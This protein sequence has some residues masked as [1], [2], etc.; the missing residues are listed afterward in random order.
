MGKFPCLGLGRA[1]RHLG[2]LRWQRFLG[3][4]FKHAVR[5]NTTHVTYVCLP[6]FYYTFA[7][8]SILG[9]DPFT[10]FPFP[11]SGA[12]NEQAGKTHAAAAGFERDRRRHVMRS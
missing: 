3:F 1:L 10:F 4:P 12:A 6:S 11:L 5:P 9:L 7:D 8:R 2:F